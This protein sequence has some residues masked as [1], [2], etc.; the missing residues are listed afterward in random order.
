MISSS[1]V[2]IS[3]LVGSEENV[4]KHKV[5]ILT[6]YE[7]LL[8]FF[9]IDITKEKTESRGESKSVAIFSN[10]MLKFLSI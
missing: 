5:N 9:N 8:L 6:C 2:Q 3:Q 4:T 7:C 1:A 10:L